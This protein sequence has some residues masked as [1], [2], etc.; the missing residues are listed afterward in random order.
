MQARA[1]YPVWG[2]PLSLGLTADSDNI[3]QHLLRAIDPE[4]A[5]SQEANATAASAA[6]SAVRKGN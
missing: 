6:D 2:T 3:K 4:F 5:A 1:C